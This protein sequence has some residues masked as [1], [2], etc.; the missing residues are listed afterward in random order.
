MI[1][2]RTKN[3]RRQ[4]DDPP[5]NDVPAQKRMALVINNIRTPAPTQTRKKSTKPQKQIE[6]VENVRKRNNQH[7]YLVK[8]QKNET[9]E[10]IDRD[11]VVDQYPEQ[12]IDYYQGVLT[13]L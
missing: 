4:A 1:I 6:R 12:V 2:A 7:E 3:K 11:L 8:W 13:F 10:W 5:Q 9:P